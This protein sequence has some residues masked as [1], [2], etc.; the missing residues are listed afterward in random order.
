MDEFFCF[1]VRVG[2]FQQTRA[3]F[4]FPFILV[5]VDTLVRS[6]MKH[7]VFQFMEFVINRDFLMDG[8]RILKITVEIPG[9]FGAFR[10]Q[11]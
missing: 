1:Q 3:V 8:E 7:D 4:E 11:V 6:Q 2:F 10:L 9:V 5:D